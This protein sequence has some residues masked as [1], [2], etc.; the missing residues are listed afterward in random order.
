LRGTALLWLVGLLLGV[1]AFAPHRQAWAGHNGDHYYYAS[2]ALQFAGVDYDTSL[3]ITAEYFHYPFSANKLDLGYLNPTVAPLIYPRV[4]LGLLALP[5][6]HLLGIRGVWFPGAACGLLSL[7]VMMRLAGRRVGP[8]AVLAIPVLVGV[9]RY[10]PEFMF[11]IYLEAPVVLATAAML[12][13]FPLGAARRGWWHAAAAAGLVPLMMLSRQVPLLPV[14]MVLGAWLWAWVGSRRLRNRWLP[15]VLTVTP[16]TVVTYGLLAR[17][18]PYDVLPFLY[19]KTNSRTAAELIGNLPAMWRQ[20]VGVDTQDVLQHDPALL[21]VTALGLV[22]LLLAVRNPVA[23]VFLGSLGSGVVTELLNGQ[24]NAFRYLS[25]SLPPLL[26]LAALALACG[27]RL[28]ARWVSRVWGLYT[29]SERERRW[30]R[31]WTGASLLRAEPSID[32]PAPDGEAARARPIAGRRARSGRLAAP[33]LAAGVWLAVLAVL[34]GT[35]ATHRAASLQGAPSLTVSADRHRGQWPFTVPT[36]TLICA[37]SDFE[38]WFVAP[39]GTRYALSGTAMADSLL[40]PRAVVLAPPGIDYGWTPVNPLI[41]AGM[42][43]CEPRR[44]FQAGAP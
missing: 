6:V 41:T 22:G 3:R 42:R 38:I 35:L 44:G 36:G 13:A 14:G 40:T 23:G 2:T 27:V 15:F 37:G 8:V 17:W 5:A 11:G 43:L 9:T 26:L 18:A 32:R 29:P 33:A 4:M 39:D 12:L 16:T 30:G 7:L 31:D 25:A 19:A 24:P 20:T 1:A 28:T 21:L 34:V 10:A